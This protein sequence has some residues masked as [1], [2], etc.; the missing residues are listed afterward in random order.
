MTAYYLLVKQS[1]NT[2]KA[3]FDVDNETE[4]HID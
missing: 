3:G 2:N 4:A 1:C